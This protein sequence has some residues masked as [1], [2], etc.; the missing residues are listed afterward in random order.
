VPIPQEL[1]DFIRRRDKFLIVGHKEP[2]GDCVGSQ[3]ALT[4]A[5]R[6]LGKEAVPCSAGPFKRPEIIPYQDRFI[7]EVDEI[8]RVGACAIILDCSALCRTGEIA[9]ALEGLPTALIDHHIAGQR[10]P[11]EFDGPVF[12][13]PSAPAVTV[14]VFALIEALGLTP[15]PEE[16]DL[17]LFGL[18]TDTGFFRHIDETGAETFGYVSR[19]VRLGASPKR[20]FQRI[21]GGKSLN[22]RYLL[23]IQLSRVR[24]YFG[25]KLL[26]TSEE[27][28]ETQRFGLEGRDSDSLYQLLQA[29]DGAEAI[30][31][32]RQET[33]E[34]CTIA[35]RS[36][37]KIDVSAIAAD[38]GGGGHKN[39]AGISI[40]GTIDDLRPRILG[41]FERVFPSDAQG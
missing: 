11:G 34:N 19:M 31:V 5:L 21:N 8:R 37:D 39:A 32:I 18:C 25:G 28:A 15:T 41:A 9:K 16:A 29:V 12:L 2:D 36:R 14:M 24:A 27:Y 20:A 22:S 40:A 10:V 4:S 3:L 33:P 7:S 26:F 30:A 13:E 23:G 38:F 1:L 35:L 17:L 6:R